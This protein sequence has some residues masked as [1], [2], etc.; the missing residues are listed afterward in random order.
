MLEATQAYKAAIVGD[1][2]KMLL[3]RAKRS[4]RPKTSQKRKSFRINSA[5][6]RKKTN[7]QRKLLW[8]KQNL[9]KRLLRPI[10]TSN[11]PSDT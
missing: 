11:N 3:K 7:L 6:S 9:R 8:K 10:R 2:R 5:T 4:H 1:S